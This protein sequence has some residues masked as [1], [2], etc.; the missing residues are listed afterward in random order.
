MV[1]L[2]VLLGLMLLLLLLTA[3]GGWAAAPVIES[4]AITLTQATGD[5]ADPPTEVHVVRFHDADGVADLTQ[6]TLQA[7]FGDPSTFVPGSSGV[8]TW[9]VVGPDTV[10]LTVEVSLWS[11]AGSTFIYTI[12]DA[13]ANTDAI[14]VSGAPPFTEDLLLT[15]PTD[16]GGIISKVAPSFAW[17]GAQPEASMVV[18]VHSLLWDPP[19]WSYDAGS[20]TSV[21]YNTDGT[22]SQTQLTPGCSY[23]IS[24]FSD[25]QAATSDPRVTV[26][27]EQWYAHRVLVYSADPVIAAVRI[28][29]ATDARGPCWALAWDRVSVD[30]T[31]GDGYG[32]IASISI[33]DPAGVTHDFAPGSPAWHYV[34]AYT[35]SVMWDAEA[36][37]GDP[38]PGGYAIVAR[39]AGG[40]ETTLST[41]DIP[42]NPPFQMISPPADGTT[43]DTVPIFSWSAPEGAEVNLTLE[44]EAD[45]W[46]L[47]PW[48]RYTVTGGSV[49]YN[50][51]GHARNPEL[52]P[53]YSYLLSLHYWQDELLPGSRVIVTPNQYLSSRFT[54]AAAG[55]AT[56]SLPGT[57]AYGVCF[58]GRLGW[59]DHRA[60]VRDRLH[61]AP[62][63]RA[64]GCPLPRLGVGRPRAALHDVGSHGHQP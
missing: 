44:E 30:V 32:N 34:D 51:D 43:T 41:P 63:A 39:G 50:D 11:G 53:G 27:T 13:A 45:T 26:H 36:A 7:P 33:T 58:E 29:R 23:I 64:G 38:T 56:P 2:V 28:I 52:L 5:Y 57:L 37:L 25:R 54:V 8:G 4:V 3:A 20:A 48:Q 55:V 9:T 17:A 12:S 62:L 10:E 60:S 42:A 24:L 47:P 18:S 46:Y 61:R 15:S 35:A 6:V 1:R 16:T 59:A 14:T 31:D 21:A 49:A 19:V 22:A 40:Y